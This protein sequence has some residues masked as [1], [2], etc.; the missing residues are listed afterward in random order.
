MSSQLRGFQ[1]KGVV[2]TKPYERDNI[3]SKSVSLNQAN[4]IIA[5]TKSFSG[6]MGFEVSNV[7]DDLSGAA[8]VNVEMSISGKNWEQATDVNDADLTYSL[9]SGATIMESI[10]GIPDG[11]FLRIVVEENLTGTLEVVT[12][13]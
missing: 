12:K 7:A 10:S 2:S 13:I 3:Q 1:Q 5:N 11:V 4:Q 6:G 9:V 8:T